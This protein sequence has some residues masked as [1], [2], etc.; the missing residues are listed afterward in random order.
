MTL[1]DLR[2]RVTKVIEDNDKQG[3]SDRNDK[4]VFVYMVRDTHRKYARFWA[5]ENILGCLYG[6][7]EYEG[8]VIEIKEDQE[9]KWRA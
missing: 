4:P 5:A 1:N 8:F 3:W 6:F 2:D 7:G 9:L